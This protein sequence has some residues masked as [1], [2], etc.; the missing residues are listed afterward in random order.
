MRNEQFGESSLDPKR[1]PRNDV[2]RYFSFSEKFYGVFPEFQSS[3]YSA[4]G[5]PL[6]TLGYFV[7]YTYGLWFI[8]VKRERE[9]KKNGGMLWFGKPRYD[10]VAAVVYVLVSASS[11]WV[12]II[13]SVGVF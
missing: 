7:L 4:V 8:D 11:W 5:R 3:I 10:I 1:Q 12:S 9:R 6:L 13:S 2:T